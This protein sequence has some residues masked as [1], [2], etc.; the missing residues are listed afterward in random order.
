MGWKI[1]FTQPISYIARPG[2]RGGHCLGD[3]HPGMTLPH[4][5]PSPCRRRGA[6]LGALHVRRGRVASGWSVWV[7]G[8]VARVVGRG[9]LVGVYSNGVHT[10][11]SCST[12]ERLLSVCTGASSVCDLFSRLR[13]TAT[14][15]SAV[16]TLLC[17]TRR[18]V[19]Y[20]AARIFAALRSAPGGVIHS[21]ERRVWRVP[22]RVTTDTRLSQPPRDCCAASR[23]PS[24]MQF[25][26][27]LS[28]M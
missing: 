14:N 13:V 11:T 17:Y 3:G 12:Q 10:V 2:C 1:Q 7:V 28:Q 25:F 27:A 26:V 23:A 21:H 24:S 6:G 8:V 9:V 16:Y 19:S 15:L 4:L 20:V 22:R 5:I 18:C